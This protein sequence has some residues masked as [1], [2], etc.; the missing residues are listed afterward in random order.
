MNGVDTRGLL[1]LRLNCVPRVT[2]RFIYRNTYIYIIIGF[3]FFIISAYLP[4]YKNARAIIVE[5]VRSAA[6]R[7]PRE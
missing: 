7:Q 3:F 4:R 6:T 5:N 2:L 1:R